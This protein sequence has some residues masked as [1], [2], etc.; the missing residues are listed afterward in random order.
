MGPWK[1]NIDCPYPA[2]CPLPQ[3]SDAAKDTL[4]R[5][6]ELLGRTLQELQRHQVLLEWQ[7]QSLKIAAVLEDLKEPSLRIGI[8]IE[9]SENW[10]VRLILAWSGQGPMA[11]SNVMRLRIPSPPGLEM[12]TWQEA[13]EELEEV[14]EAVN[15]S[16]AHR[17]FALEIAPDIN[18]TPADTA[19]LDVAAWRQMP[20]QLLAPDVLA[21]LN[22]N[23]LDAQLPQTSAATPRPRM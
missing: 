15:A 23:A 22:A 6:R 20:Q 5:A 1:Q 21:A 19:L 8:A 17:E 18:T 12:P 13:L 7:L 14:Q 3:A 10:K 9:E 2:P 11:L 16:F 4:R